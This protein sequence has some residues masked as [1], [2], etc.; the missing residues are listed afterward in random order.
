M[1]EPF[2]NMY[3][4][5][6]FDLFTK[7][8]RLVID[9]FDAHGFVSQIMD[10]EWEGRE[11]K[12]RWIHITSILKKFL[13]ADYKEAIAKILEL[14]DHVKS[15]RPDFSVI[16]DTKFGLMLEY[17][18]ILNNYV[19]QYGL[20]DYETSVKAIEKITQFT[21][22]EFVTHPFIIKYPDEMMKQMLVWSKHEHWGVRRLSSE[23]CRPRLPWAMA[24][25][26]LKKDPTPIIPILENLK[27]DPARFVRLSVANNLN[28]I[29]KDNPE[30]VIDLAKKWKGESKEV[31]WIIKH[32]CRTLLKQGIPEVMELF[33]FDS[34]RNNIS[35]EDFQISSLKVK[36]G[37]SLESKYGLNMVFITKK[38]MER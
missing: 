24:L 15:T 14:L 13:P 5:Q 30:I 1:A 6:F 36:V 34:I 29:A 22:C 9:D 38:Q 35:M 2:K 7:D 26:N 23:G 32:G 20:D 16:D 21:S 28:D 31:D 4:K 33:G 11:L 8:L 3:N 10:D 27:N 37:D 19:E 25:P 18:V 12:Q 17:G